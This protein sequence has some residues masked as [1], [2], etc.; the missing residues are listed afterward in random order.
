M[1][2]MFNILEEKLC[3]LVVASPPPRRHDPPA[4]SLQVK[5]CIEKRPL[6]WLQIIMMEI[7]LPKAL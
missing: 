7:E 6:Y 4:P 1:F 3:S 5:L 2:S